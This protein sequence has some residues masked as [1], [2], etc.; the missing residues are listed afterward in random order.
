MIE[1]WFCD[2]T[3]SERWPHYTRAN[4]GEVLATPATPLGQTY[5]W[6][7]AMLQGWRGRNRVRTSKTRTRPGRLTMYRSGVSCPARPLRV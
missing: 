5:S 3:P 1:K 7:N 2:W 4:A 6:E